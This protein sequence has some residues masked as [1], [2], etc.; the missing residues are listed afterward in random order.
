MPPHV[1]KPGAGDTRPRGVRIAD[2]EYGS[3]ITSQCMPVDKIRVGKRHR[4]D[5]GDRAT[6]GAVML[7]VTRDV[8]DLDGIIAARLPTNAAAWR[9][10]LT[11]MTTGNGHPI[12]ALDCQSGG[13]EVSPVRQNERGVI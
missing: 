13:A 9:L 10:G 1:P 5:I 11:V 8:I 4:K 2:G 6:N 12:F 3:P 7:T